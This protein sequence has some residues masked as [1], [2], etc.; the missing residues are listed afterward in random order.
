MGLLAAAG[1]KRR[2]DTTGWCVV[3][4]VIPPD[5]LVAAQQALPG[6]FPTADEFAD[7]VDPDRNAPFFTEAGAPHPQFPFE[8]EA[9]NR[10]ALHDSIID[11]AQQVLEL[12]DI[13]AVSSIA[14]REVRA[15]PLQTTNSSSTSTT[16][17]TRWSSP[18]PTSGTST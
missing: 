9:L 4:D 12:D 7:R 16:P 6:V 18:A 8:A 17:T 13:R 1:Y 10:V 5:L 15:T 11:L 14:E 3:E 2:W